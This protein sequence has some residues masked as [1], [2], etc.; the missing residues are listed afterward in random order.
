MFSHINLFLIFIN[1][2]VP[3]KDNLH[4]HP[5]QR[6][7]FV[8]TQNITKVVKRNLKVIVKTTLERN[9]LFFPER[10]LSDINL[11]RPDI[12]INNLNYADG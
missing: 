9:W 7:Q 10:D 1:L 2:G 8:I 6:C 4:L 12:G 11:T 3:P 5:Q